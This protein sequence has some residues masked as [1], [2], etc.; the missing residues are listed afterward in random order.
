L[1]ETARPAGAALVMAAEGSAI[2]GEAGSRIRETAIAFDGAGQQLYAIIA[3]PADVERLPL[4]VILY[5]AGAIRRIGPNR[6]W[7]ETARR[8]A[9]AGVPV[10]R[11]DV[12]GIGDAAG[13]GGVYR[14]SDDPFYDP[15]LI[16]QAHAV[17]DL[18]SQRGLPDHFALGGLCSGAFWAFQAALAD[19][20]VRSVIMLNPRL[21]FFDP[22]SDGQ[23]E[24]RKLRQILTPSGLRRI[25]LEKLKWKRVARLG[26]HL[27][28]REERR[29]SG[30]ASEALET[31][32]SRGQQVVMGFS[33]EEPL[34]DELRRELTPPELQ[35]LNVHVAEL[36]CKSPTLKPAKAQTAGQLLIDEALQR[37]LQTS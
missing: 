25:K 1:R 7:T 9:S 17:L 12:E 35:R 18:A 20:R 27:L 31:L 19:P 26:S 8:W 11:V 28:R 13:D 2:L 29:A 16:E 10:I 30:S 4:T 32:R 14:E 5:N 34:Y 33:S 15:R 24:L 3:E 22:R 23:R 21:L 37:A 6:M 36:P